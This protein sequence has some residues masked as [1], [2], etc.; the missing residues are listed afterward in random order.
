V[1]LKW[2]KRLGFAKPHDAIANHV[3]EDDSAFHGVGVQT[4]LKLDG[5]LAIQTVNKKFINESGLYSLIFGAAKQGNNKEIK[6]KAKTFKR[7]VTSEVLPSIRKHGAYMTPETIEQALLNPDTIIRIATELKEERS[8]RILAETQIH[9]EKPYTDFGKI[10]AL[11][12]GAIN[13][14]AFSKLIY[15]KHGINIGRNRLMQWLRDKGYLIKQEGREKNFPKQVYIE[16]KLFR[17]SPTFVVRTEGNV[18]SGT[19]LITGKGQIKLMEL[20]KKDFQKE[21]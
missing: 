13:V 16:Q 10:V 3:D 11:S 2:R 17:L 19:P 8:K 1:Q 18:Q 9:E 20:L 12:D 5:G 15:D 14:G 4:G 7:W 6:E 21:Q